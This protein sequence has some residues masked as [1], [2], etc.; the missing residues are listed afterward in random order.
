ML[1]Q[2]P[3]PLFA[4]AHNGNVFDFPVLFNEIQSASVDGTSA[5]SLISMACVDSLSFFRDMHRLMNDADILQD[6]QEQTSATSTT[7]IEPMV[8]TTRCGYVEIP[9]KSTAHR[10]VP[11]MKLDQ[12]YAREFNRTPQ[13][14][15]HRAENDC[16]ILLATLRLYLPD[17]LEWIENNHR[18][19]RDFFPLPSKSSSKGPSKPPAPTKRPLR[20]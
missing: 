13:F 8:S 19:L 14:P 10:P 9:A 16:L 2:V 5:S 18:P 11:S 3:S 4:L 1:L 12:I 17:W 6:P 7:T 15:S 20:L